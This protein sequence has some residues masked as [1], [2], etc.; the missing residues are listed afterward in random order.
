MQNIY[1]C[2]GHE[3]RYTGASQ[4]ADGLEVGVPSRV[5]VGVSFVTAIYYY[6]YY[7]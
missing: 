5:R 2:S 6:Y 3:V 4:A 1:Y 7:Y